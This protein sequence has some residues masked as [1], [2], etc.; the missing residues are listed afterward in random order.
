MD[1]VDS[2]TRSRIM[3]AVHSENTKP[4]RV[5]RSVVHRLGYRYR[6]H[7]AALPGRP[8]LVFACR[9]KVLFVHGCFWHRH[10]NCR[11]AS[12][13]KTR[14]KFWQAKFDSNVARDKATVRQLRKMGWAVMTVWQCELKKPDRLA[15][16]LDRFLRA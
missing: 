3:A 9:R 6:L 7:V 16:R 13:P 8:D 4:E 15:Q 5:V 1:H 10:G 12:M 11:Y 14:R 2:I